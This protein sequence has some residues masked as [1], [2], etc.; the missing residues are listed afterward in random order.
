MKGKP[1]FVM[2]LLENT[3]NPSKVLNKALVDLKMQL[4]ITD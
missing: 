2:E 3:S 4:N 1:E